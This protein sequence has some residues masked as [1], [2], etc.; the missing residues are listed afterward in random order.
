MGGVAIP[1]T[2][3]AGHPFAVDSFA[4]GHPAEVELPDGSASLHFART[5]SSNSEPSPSCPPVTNAGLSSEVSLSRLWFQLPENDQQRFGSCFSG[6][7][8]KVL[9]F[10]LTSPGSDSCKTRRRSA[11][12]AIVRK[13]PALP[14]RDGHS[15]RV[16]SSAECAELGCKFKRSPARIPDLPGMCASMNTSNRPL[17]RAS[18]FARFPSIPW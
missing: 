7:L 11:P 17:P 1:N 16:S 18:T 8:L 14:D 3:T 5:E 12:M 10:P 13:P 6:M 9:G 2:S 15:S 4:A